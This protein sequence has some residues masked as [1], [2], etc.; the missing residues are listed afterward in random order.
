MLRHSAVKQKRQLLDPTTAALFPAPKTPV[1]RLGH[2]Q[3]ASFIWRAIPVD[4]ENL[5][6]GE[7]RPRSTGRLDVPIRKT[8]RQKAGLKGDEISPAR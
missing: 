6:V 8:P 4:G 2:P 1:Q 7:T 3:T 5:L